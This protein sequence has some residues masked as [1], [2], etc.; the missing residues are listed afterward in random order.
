M[1]AAKPAYTPSQNYENDSQ[2]VIFKEE[3][4]F[5]NEK[6]IYTV[7]YGTDNSKNKLII[8]IIK[9]STKNICFYQ[10]ENSLMELHK[11]N[12]LFKLYEDI[13][14]LIIN[15]KK[16]K[17]EILEKD[18]E[19]YLIFIFYM[20]D[21]SGEQQQ[22][23]FQLI[24]YFLNP[25]IIINNLSSEIE[26]LKKII[27]EK[28]AEIL[29]LKKNNQEKPLNEQ[30]DLK[31]KNKLLEEEIVNLNNSIS[32]LK[33]ENS[34]LND[35]ILSL[36][37]DKERLN[38]EYS[39]IKNLYDQIDKQLDEL[40]KKYT[41]EITKTRAYD[42]YLNQ[43]NKRYQKY[44]SNIKCDDSK[45]I[46]EINFEFQ[47]LFNY[48]KYNEGSF[49]FKN[50]KLLYRGSRDG[51]KTKKCHELCDNKNDVLIII[52]SETDNIFGGY[53]KIGF[54][55]KDL[56]SEYKIDNKCFLFSYSKGKIYPPI[57]EKKNICH[58]SDAS[59]LCF[60]QSLGFFDNFM[61][62]NENRIYK[63]S[64]KNYFNG[65]DDACEMNAGVDRFKCKEIE[66]YQFV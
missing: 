55:T 14:N 59:G 4:T 60:A 46:T 32:S 35:S 57:Q 19:K 5:Q 62:S 18:N 43:L 2:L 7:K 12:K 31:N 21:P 44:F 28:D 47:F 27:K 66:V 10:I 41:K 17:Y 20:S 29:N 45:I 38:N 34:Q 6:G 65:M 56:N 13:E 9:E 1:D 53:S 64:I 49:N 11:M 25:D 50:L 24:K 54:K 30:N 39:T 42:N 3:V 58:I 37:Q 15:F 48:I 16:F 22:N 8:R 23:E 33:Q 52:K 40:N 36:K 26:S 63:L 51:D 61:N